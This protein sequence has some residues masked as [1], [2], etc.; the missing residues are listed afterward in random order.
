MS[1]KRAMRLQDLLFEDII[2]S[3]AGSCFVNVSRLFYF[4]LR[5]LREF[6]DDLIWLY[7]SRTVLIK[8]LLCYHLVN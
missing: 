1:L 6:D 8:S 2:D 4:I 5:F 7:L 3:A